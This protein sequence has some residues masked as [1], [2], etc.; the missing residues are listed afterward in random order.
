V[1]GG[2][3]QYSTDSDWKHPH[4][5]KLLA[6]QADDMRAYTQGYLVLG[7]GAYLEAAKSIHRYVTQFLMSPEGAST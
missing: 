2:A 7:D 4:F 6:I 5:E 1:W 3:Y